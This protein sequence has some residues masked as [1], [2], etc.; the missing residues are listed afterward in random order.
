M[1]IENI[2]DWKLSLNSE[3]L[4]QILS[5]TQGI[6]QS[7]VI[8]KALDGTVYI[9]TIGTGNKYAD[10]TLFASREESEAINSAEA[11]GAYVKAV[12]REKN[13]YGYIEAAPTWTAKVEGE[14]YTSTIKL[15]I[16]VEEVST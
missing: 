6:E 14:W 4:A 3:V 1:S 11:L 15:L 5:Y 16:Q 13:V 9:Q 12:Y 7:K 10:I 2:N 8:S